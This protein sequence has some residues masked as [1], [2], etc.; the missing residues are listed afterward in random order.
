MITAPTACADVP[1]GTGTLNIITRKLTAENIA[2][3]GTRRAGSCA[4]TLR[5]A[6]ANVGTA[7]A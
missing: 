4:L 6:T 2:S 3:V 1:S 7:T 5:E